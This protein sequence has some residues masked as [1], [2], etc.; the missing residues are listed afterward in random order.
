M[1]GDFQ[2]EIAVAPRVDELVFGWLAQGE[3]AEYEGPGIVA[4][5]L[6]A[7]LSLFPDQLNGL[8]L[9][10]SPLGDA[11]MRKQ[12]LYGCQAAGLTL[13]FVPSF[14][15]LASE[16]VDSVVLSAFAL[17]LRGIEAD[18]RRSWGH[19]SPPFPP[20]VGDSGSVADSGLR[21]GCGFCRTLP[22]FAELSSLSSLA[23]TSLHELAVMRSRVRTPPGPP[24]TR[25]STVRYD[26][27]Q[28]SV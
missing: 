1:G 17:V 16:R 4:D 24:P 6:S 10:E 28:A 15:K 8:Q 2:E 13:M 11:N 25:S 27:A 23:A 14:R 26:D 7:T 19:A 3:A 22:G 9:L 18:V 21:L 12:G 5:L 20:L